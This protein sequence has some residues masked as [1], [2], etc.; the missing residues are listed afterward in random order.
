M[1]AGWKSL[2]RRIKKRDQESSFS[3]EKE[4]KRLLGFCG[5]SVRGHSGSGALLRVYMAA[6]GAWRTHRCS[7]GI[8]R[9]TLSCKG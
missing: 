3:E 4:A 6:N 5:V 1:S 2:R 8:S 7:A 9:F